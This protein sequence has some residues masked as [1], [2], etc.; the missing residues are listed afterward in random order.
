V[1][2]RATARFPKQSLRLHFETRDGATP[3]M[4]IFAEPV[5]ENTIEQIQATNKRKIEKFES[6]VLGVATSKLTEE[7]KEAEWARLRAKVEEEMQQDELGIEKTNEADAKREAELDELVVQKQLRAD[8]LFA[9]TAT[10]GDRDG[11]GD[12][13]GKDETLEKEKRQ[14]GELLEQYEIHDEERERILLQ[15]RDENMEEGENPD[16]QATAEEV[17]AQDVEEADRREES[18][19]EEVTPL[20]METNEAGLDTPEI[21]PDGGLTGHTIKEA[22]KAGDAKLDAHQAAAPSTAGQTK[23]KPVNGADSID[24]ESTKDPLLAMTLVIRN[25]VNNEYVVRPE[26]LEGSEKWEVEY[27]LSEV[28]VL[29][30]AHKLYRM[31]KERRSKALSRNR[32]SNAKNT[33]NDTYIAG[34][35]KMS[36]KGRVWREKQDEIEKELP[37]KILEVNGGK[38]VYK[39]G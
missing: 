22:I 28:A 27:A 37:V 23:K 38:K 14:D 31:A 34:I 10:E 2:D 30:S 33:W 18:A 12:D 29:E 36:E 21:I 3:F 7:Q 24:D 25:K 35:Q 15:G 19:S 9:A 26:S 32:D 11:N 17:V 5:A 20:N 39:E 13:K 6:E 16:E 8:Q 1:L 4:Y